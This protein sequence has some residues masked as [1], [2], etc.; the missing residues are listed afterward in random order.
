MQNAKLYSADTT[1][2]LIPQ[3]DGNLVT[4]AQ[5]G[6]S[7]LAISHTRLVVEEHA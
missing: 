1:V 7:V 5:I 3:A 4:Y 6:C 2:C